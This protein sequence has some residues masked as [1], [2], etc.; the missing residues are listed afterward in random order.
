LHEAL[1][2]PSPQ[3]AAE[4]LVSLANQNGGPDN[5]TALVVRP[6]GS[7]EAEPGD[8]IGPVGEA[9]GSGPAL[10]LANLPRNWRIVLLAAAIVVI[11]AILVGLTLL[12]SGSAPPD[13]PG[14]N[15]PAS[16]VPTQTLIPVDTGQSEPSGSTEQAPQPLLTATLRPVI[17]GVIVAWPS[18]NV[19]RGPSVLD[20][21]LVSLQQGTRVRVLCRAE[22]T[23]G[24]PWLKIKYSD[25]EGFIRS[26]LVEVEGAGPSDIQQCE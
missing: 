3:E 11:L 19:R 21:L 1:A 7:A 22:V 2:S 10:S 16:V 15:L 14:V 5:V 17:D 12:L 13:S 8:G 20:P 4:Q 23:S 25:A 9:Q 26:D 6:F 18:G 24:P